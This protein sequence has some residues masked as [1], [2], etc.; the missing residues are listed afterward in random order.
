LLKLCLMNVSLFQAAAA[1]NANARWQEVIAENLAA[2]SI[3]GFKK[4]ELSFG[5]IEAG[6]MANS[7]NGTQPFTLPRA[8]VTTNFRPGEFRFTGVKTDVALEGRGFFAVQLPD[9]N[10]A[11]TRDGEFQ[12]NSTGQLVTK[13]GFPVLGDNGPMQ[14][15]LN[16]SAPLSISDSGQVTQGAE[17]RGTLRLVDFNDS[18]LLTPI[19]RSYFLANHPDLRTEEAPDTTVRQGYLEA[20]NTAAAEE[21]AHLI[22][23]MRIYEANQRVIQAHDERMGKTI[24]ELGDPR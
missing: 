17:V 2:S 1:L 9:G 8:A 13:Q 24:M 16:I 14:V 18:K 7:V 21:M 15:D 6:L 19:S 22:A 3:P 5:A 10:T 23:A 4:Q 12:I 11:Y 20:A